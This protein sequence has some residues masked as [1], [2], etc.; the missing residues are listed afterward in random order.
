M[1]AKPS[2][3]WRSGHCSQPIAAAPDAHARCKVVAGDLTCSCACHATPPDPVAAV[4]TAVQVLADGTDALLEACTDPQAT[5]MAELLLDVQLARIALQN[6]ERDIEAA[7]AKAMTGEQALTPT[8]RA[9]RSRATDR[10]AWSHDEW[11]RDVRRQV[12][13]KHGL[14]GATIVSADGE[15]LD[16]GALHTLLAD[17]Q[18][19]HGAAAPK[20]TAL[21]ELGLD[22]RDYCESTPGAWHVKVQRLVNDSVTEVA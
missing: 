17:L 8:L 16:K 21:R 13:R 15:E 6:V 7:C 19:V 4:T 2:R 10:K 14:L 20:T 18:N 12:I 5:D 11:K 3:P 9:E 1:T 22:S